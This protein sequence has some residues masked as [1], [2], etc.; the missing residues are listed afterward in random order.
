MK[1]WLLF[2]LLAS[3]GQA[4]T[5]ADW[6]GDPQTSDCSDNG[7]T[8][9]KHGTVAHPDGWVGLW[10][11]QSKT[12]DYL[13]IPITARP[14][15]SA[16]SVDVAFNIT[17]TAGTLQRQVY[18]YSFDTGTG[19]DE[20]Y[21]YMIAAPKPAGTGSLKVLWTD[22]SGVAHSKIYSTNAYFDGNDHDMQVSWGG[23]GVETFLDSARKSQLSTDGS[24]IGFGSSD[25]NVF[26]KIGAPDNI[27]EA[28]AIYIGEVLLTDEEYSTPTVTPTSTSSQTTTPTSTL[29]PTI[30]I[31]IT[32]TT[33]QTPTW[34]PTATKTP[35]GTQ[36]Y[37]FSPTLTKTPTISP[38]PSNSPVYSPTV[39]PTISATNTPSVSPTSTTTRTF[40]LTP[41][42][43]PLSRT[44]DGFTAVGNGPQHTTASGA[45]T[46]LAQ[47]TGADASDETFTVDIQGFTP[48]G[49]WKTIGTLSEINPG[50]GVKATF[51]KEQNLVLIR[52]RVRKLTINSARMISVRT[53]EY[54]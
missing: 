8:L 42:A 6:C 3:A 1:K 14:S 23:V 27:N 7:N 38:T 51:P 36:S 9:T 46:L 50:D 26:S 16:G 30:T 40:T 20:R 19:A 53:W 43:T 49:S 2:F 45:R 44:M 54:Q 22:A 33:S 35:T 34:T 28:S 32:K 15:D 52:A 21:L 41:T 31:T 47:V 12:S 48:L 37:T 10:N 24:T 4:A 29:S 18:L 5:I 17:I 25:T 13:E 11:N 39:S